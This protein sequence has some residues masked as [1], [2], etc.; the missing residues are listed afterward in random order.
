M[1]SIPTP[2]ST[3]ARRRTT[4]QTARRRTAISF[5]SLVLTVAAVAG[6]FIVV[7]LG[8]VDGDGSG[9]DDAVTHLGVGMVVVGGLFGLISLVTMITGL[10]ATVAATREHRYSRAQITSAWIGTALNIGVHLFFPILRSV[11]L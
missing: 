8:T 9:G 7:L 2:E 3:D 1:S 11:V 6:G 10:F 4:L 5:G